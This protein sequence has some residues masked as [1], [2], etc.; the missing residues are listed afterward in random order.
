MKFETISNRKSIVS[1]KEYIYKRTIINVY[2]QTE[3]ADQ[4]QN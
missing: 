3:T 4:V 1:F 2:V